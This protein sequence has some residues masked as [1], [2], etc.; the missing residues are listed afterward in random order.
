[1]VIFF[2][3]MVMFLKNVFMYFSGAWEEEDFTGF[4]IHRTHVSYI[5]YD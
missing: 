1:M 3:N 5:K 4:K 2:K